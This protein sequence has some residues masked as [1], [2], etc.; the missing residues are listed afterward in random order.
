MVFADDELEL[1]EVLAAEVVVGLCVLVVV[2][3]L[4]VVVCTLDEVVLVLVAAGVELV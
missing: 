1:D 4:V 3:V 2:L